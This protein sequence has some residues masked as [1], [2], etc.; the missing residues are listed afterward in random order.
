MQDK[1]YSLLRPFDLEAAK[2]G[3]AICYHGDG[4]V[5]L[6]VTVT[7]AAGICGRWETTDKEL[8]WTAKQLEETFRLAPLC[9]VEGRPVY[10]GD[11][12]YYKG[13]GQKEVATATGP[14]KNGSCDGF[15]YR[16]KITGDGNYAPA[17]CFTWKLPKVKRNVKLVAFI[18]EQGFLRWVRE[19]LF[20][21]RGV[22]VPFEDRVIEIE[23]PAEVAK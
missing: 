4:E 18:D 13:F 14:H 23:D 9:W 5:L 8:Y 1:D 19:E 16:G 11:V 22:R 10:R 17:D 20:A 7:K 6:D 2:R 3:E 15:S 12:L 21:N